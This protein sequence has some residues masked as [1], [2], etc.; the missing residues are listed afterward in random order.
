MPARQSQTARRVDLSRALSY[1]GL[2]ANEEELNDDTCVERAKAGDEE[3]VAEL[4][5]RHRERLRRMVELRLDHRVRR[6]VDA[7]DVLQD[8]YVDLT[9]QLPNYVKDPKLPFFLWLRRITG[10]RLAKVHRDHLGTLKRNAALE[11]SFYRGGMPEASSHFLASKLIGR[12]TSASQ[13]VIRAEMQ[14]KLQEALNSMNESDREILALRH[15]EQLD[16][17]EVAVLLD[18]SESAASHRFYRA[19]RR[20]KNNLKKIPGM[21]D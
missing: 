18:I 7:S 3:A 11:V 5:S 21:L 9:S 4:F 16:N 8:A 6:R 15:I 2:M 10:Q 13:K 14:I 17:N 12:F 1:V 19:I 20:L